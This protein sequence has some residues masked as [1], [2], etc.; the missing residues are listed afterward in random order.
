MRG[1]DLTVN[2]LFVCF[3]KKSLVFYHQMHIVIAMG[4]LYAVLDVGRELFDYYKPLSNVLLGIHP[5][6]LHF[7]VSTKLMGWLTKFPKILL[8]RLISV[9]F[10]ILPD[11]RKNRTIMGFMDLQF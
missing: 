11:I 6:M 2:Q 7:L 8:V 3:L 10:L 4:R 5:E 1:R 9:L